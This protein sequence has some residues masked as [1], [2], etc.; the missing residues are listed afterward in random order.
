MSF[1]SV[2]TTELP[3]P[4]GQQ[5]LPDTGLWHPS[6]QTTPSPPD[7]RHNLQ[8]EGSTHFP[9]WLHP[10]S[11]AHDICSL[12]WHQS[13]IKH[14]DVPSGVHALREPLTQFRRKGQHGKQRTNSRHILRTF[15]ELCNMLPSLRLSLSPVFS[16]SIEILTFA[17]YP[18]S[19]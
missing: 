14:A 13:A 1:T 5:P 16:D 11:S 3:D 2:G 19:L 17:R 10:F 4:Q 9:L 18:G 6:P 15:I 8:G 7:P 12:L